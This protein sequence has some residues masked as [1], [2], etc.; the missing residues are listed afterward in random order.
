MKIKKKSV[1]TQTKNP[2][3]WTKNLIGFEICQI[4][5]CCKSD[6]KSLIQAWV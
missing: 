5:K 1:T 6:L 4:L 2:Y 3:T